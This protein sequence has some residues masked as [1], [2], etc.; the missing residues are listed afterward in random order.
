MVQAAALNAKFSVITML[1]HL[2]NRNKLNRYWILNFYSLVIY[3][4][5]FLS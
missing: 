4:I 2:S 1:T 3:E 5:V